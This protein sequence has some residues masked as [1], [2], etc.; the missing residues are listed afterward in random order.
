MAISSQPNA[1]PRST[2]DLIAEAERKRDAFEQRFLINQEHGEPSE[3]DRP[4]S[5]EPPNEAA[6]PTGR[7][8]VRD[9]L[10][11]H[12]LR[13]AGAEPG[14]D[15]APIMFRFLARYVVTF[16]EMENALLEMDIFQALKARRFEFSHIWEGVQHQPIASRATVRFLR[17]YLP[18]GSPLRHCTISEMARQLR[19]FEKVK[20]A[21]PRPDQR[22]IRNIL[23]HYAETL[24]SWGIEPAVKGTP[25]LRKA[26]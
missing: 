13:E 5:P 11:E 15:R 22:R 9:F 6:L 7:E 2:A 23:R 21:K 8:L 17:R 19:W 4:D 12:G 14:D 24:Q 1:A 26:V 25:G 3:P 18:E 10:F 20:D 16:P